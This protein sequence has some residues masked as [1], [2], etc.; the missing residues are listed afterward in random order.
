M[1]EAETSDD[2]KLT[3]PCPANVDGA[4][5]SVY[6]GVDFSVPHYVWNEAEGMYVKSP[7]T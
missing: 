3:V 1:F 7:G 2:Y 4:L 5:A 6:P